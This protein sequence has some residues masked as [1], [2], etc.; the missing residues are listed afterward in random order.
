MPFVYL[1]CF[2]SNVVRRAS[3]TPLKQFYSLLPVPFFGLKTPQ[4]CFT[5]ILF[6]VVFILQEVGCWEDTT[7]F[8]FPK[9]PPVPSEAA[10]GNFSSD[11]QNQ[12][13]PLVLFGF[14]HCYVSPS[15][16][17]KKIKLLCPNFLSVSK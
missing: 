10:A 7:L 4:P 14:S 16:A 2:L 8:T 11:S 9:V 6:K 13:V 1:N 15:P 5:R 12:Q 3:P 17:R